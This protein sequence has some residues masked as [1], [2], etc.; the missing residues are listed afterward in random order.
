MGNQPLTLYI[1]AHIK[2]IEIGDA[3]HIGAVVHG[4]PAVL[5]VNTVVTADTLQY[6]E[7]TFT[8]GEGHRGGGQDRAVSGNDALLGLL[9]QIHIIQNGAA[10]DGEGTGVLLAGI[11]RGILRL[12]RN[13]LSLGYRVGQILI[14]ACGGVN[15]LLVFFLFR[16]LLLGFF[17]FWL[18]LFG[19]FLLRC[20]LLGRVL[21]YILLFRAVF[22]G[23]FRFGCVLLG[24]IVLCRIGLFRIWLC[25]V[26]F[27][28]FRC[29]LH[30]GVAGFIISSGGAA[31]ASCQR[32]QRQRR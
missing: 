5:H 21:L 16:L 14:F 20:L 11:H 15:N 12:H 6:V 31:A 1:P 24:G 29:L 17:L 27:F 30:S 4:R 32:Q 10:G 3:L 7:N 22:F 8:L 18:F 26:G 9:A 19:F 13:R 23:I 2:F 28:L 25:R